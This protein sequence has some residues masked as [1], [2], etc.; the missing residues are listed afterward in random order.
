MPVEVAQ[1]DVLAER[2]TVEGRPETDR[3]HSRK[4]YLDGRKRRGG[5][6]ES[7]HRRL[8]GTTPTEGRVGKNGFGG[9]FVDPKVVDSDDRCEPPRYCSPTHWLGN[10]FR[11]SCHGRLDRAGHL[12]GGEDRRPDG[13]TDAST[14]HSLRWGSS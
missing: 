5:Q 11:P 8:L 9:R 3:V 4:G 1:L 10:G 2:E 12:L 13:I 7:P 14:H 6:F